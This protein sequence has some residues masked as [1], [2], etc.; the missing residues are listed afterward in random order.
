M[1]D[2]TYWK[3][4]VANRLRER[5]LDPTL[6]AS[7]IEELAQ[8]LDERYRSLSRDTDSALAERLTIEELDDNESLTAARPD[9]GGLERELIH[10]ERRAGAFR[11]ELGQAPSESLL[12]GVLQDVR[13][14]GRTLAKNRGFTAVAAL[15]LALGVAVNTTIFSVINAV[16]LRPLPYAEPDRLVRIWESNP[17]LGWPQFSASHPNFLDWRTHTRSMDSLVAVSSANFAI[18]AP[19]GAQIVRAV[20]A[21]ADFLPALGITPAL[22]RNFTRDEDRPGGENRV[23]L[24]TDGF[25]RRAFGAAPEIVGTTISLN[26]NSY[27]VIG[28]LPPTFDWGVNT[29]LLVPLVPD[30]ARPR[31]DHR[32]TVFGRLKSGISI[33]QAHADLSTIAADLAT[34]YPESNDGW[35]VRTATFYDW[36]IP[37]AIRESLLVLQVAVGL[38]LL[39]ACVNVANLLLARGA[40]R[41]K[42]LA[43]RIAIGASRQRIIRQ[44]LIEALVLSA[45][46][47]A[48]GLAL[49]AMVIPLL[50]AHGPATVP[51]LDEV[52]IDSRV[53]LWSMASAACAA[54]L[55]GLIPAVQAGREQARDALQDSGRGSTSGAGR[56]RTRHLLTVAEVALSVTLLIGAGLLLRS[57]AQLQTVDPGFAVPSLMSARVMLPTRANFAEPAQRVAFWNRLTEE[58][59]ALP[60][61]AA[62]STTSGAP[63]AGIGNTSTELEVPGVQPRRGEQP[64]AGWR[65]VTP[66]YFATMGIPLRGRDFS[67]AAGADAGP[68][69][70]I[71][72]SLAR[73]YWPNGDA[74]GKPIVIRSLG[75]RAHTI[76]GI[77]GDVRSGGLDADAIPTVYLSG[78][79]APFGNP[80]FLVWRTMADADTEA[81]AVREVVRRIDPTVPVFEVTTFDDLLS[82]SFG[83]RRFN[84]YLLGTFA[85][86]ALVMSA[87]GLFGVMAYLVSQRRREMGVRL[88]LGAD[89]G[90]LFRLVIGRGLVLAS[91]GALIGI[92]GAFWLTRLMTNLLYSVSPTDPL[93]FAAVTVCVV[94]VS[95]LACYVPARRATRVDPLTAL[96]GE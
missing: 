27:T 8:H 21:T 79:A 32:L 14:A 37:Q 88:A 60:G 81:A 46:G 25:W 3:T 49:A 9:R 87:V 18:T 22:G 85:A 31:G 63:L 66:D 71:S 36:L 48:A 6:H 76:V 20:T 7:V 34:R 47:S 65:I 68:Y 59:R 69:T 35:G 40:A 17:A 45:I 75:N 51:R 11:S 16:M 41:Q 54:L 73:R 28:V 64:S 82:R 72:E 52:S 43:I 93:T 80:M 95:L 58:V 10:H 26:G 33:D 84:L 2:A 12:N 70:I 44:V 13:Y 38:V 19:E 42:E 67:P 62:V 15:T 92:A 86:V 96:R 29:D 78:I 23:L 1:R 89:R 91:T 4:V 24:L 57:F 83:P 53:M 90:A 94:A 5:G 39:I 61:I 55:F 77:A 56:Q 30:P 50:V 74:L